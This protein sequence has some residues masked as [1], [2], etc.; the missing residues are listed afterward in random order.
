[1]M[2]LLAGINS[3]KL[4][5]GQK[6]NLIGFYST[7]I[8]TQY[9]LKRIVKQIFIIECYIHKFSSKTADKCVC[10]RYLWSNL[11]GLLHKKV[12]KTNIYCF[13]KNLPLSTLAGSDI[14]TRSSS[15]L[16]RWQT[17]R[18]P[19]GLGI[20]N[21]LYLTFLIIICQFLPKL[22]YKIDSR[23][24]IGD[25]FTVVPFHG[26]YSAADNWNK[27]ALQKFREDQ[28][29]YIETRYLRWNRR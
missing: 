4:D 3:T 5:L 29:T 16:C 14:T 7:L 23:G 15:L 10:I 12:M 19:R 8:S 18:V 9:H 11:W 1:M 6:K 27:F 22:F 26:N 13:Y 21:N 20:F 25:F 28:G 24:S 17:E 2:H